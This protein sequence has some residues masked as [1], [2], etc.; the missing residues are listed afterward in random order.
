MPEAEERKDT[1]PAAQKEDVQGPSAGLGDGGEITAVAD[2]LAAVALANKNEAVF[3][4]STSECYDPLSDPELWEPHSPTEDCPV[5]L[6]SL[7]LEAAKMVYMSCCGK[8]IC[9]ACMNESDRVMKITNMKRGKKELPP[10]ESFCAFCRE[11]HGK[12]P[13]ETTERLESLVNKSDARAMIEMAFL[14][15]NGLRGFPK[16]EAKTMELL[17]KAADM[18]SARAMHQLGYVYIEGTRDVPK[19]TKKGILYFENAVK[20]GNVHSRYQLG[21]VYGEKGNF[22]LAI[23]HYRLAA[24]AGSKVAV[25]EIWKLFSNGKMSKTDLEETLRAHQFACDEMESEDRRRFDA[26]KEAMAGNDK[27]LQGFYGI[28][29]EGHINAK[30][31]KEALKMHRNGSE[32]VEIFKFLAN[33]MADL[34]VSKMQNTGT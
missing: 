14:C 30:Q 24:E 8:T 12:S 23:K 10:L 9:V 34:R 7:P 29:Y 26:F 28:Y 3:G 18:G 13:A 32:E 5:C 1:H 21:R 17:K 11:P 6:V 4:P 27:I 22:H 31:L 20:M 15:Q 16:D 25:K 19:D 33:A 2:Q